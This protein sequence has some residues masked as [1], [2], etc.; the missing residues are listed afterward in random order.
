MHDMH[1]LERQLVTETTTECSESFWHW[2]YPQT[3]I[4]SNLQTLSPYLQAAVLFHSS[5]R[6]S[7]S[8][9]ISLDNPL[10][11]SKSISNFNITEFYEQ[12]AND[13]EAWSPDERQGLVLLEP[14][15]LI[16]KASERS[17]TTVSDF[18]ERAPQIQQN[19]SSSKHLT[20]SEHKKLM[21]L[22][23]GYALAFFLLAIITFYIV[24]YI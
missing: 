13:V 15:L 12:V 18:R 24:Y 19:S 16:R 8:E 9:T 5:Y 22:A 3:A 20:I 14:L 1:I 7:S 17:F 21:R 6:R 2:L 10:P 4:S 23:I 11:L